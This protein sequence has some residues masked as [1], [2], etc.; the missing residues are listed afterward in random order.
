M[1]VPKDKMIYI[2]YILSSKVKTPIIVPR[3]W[4]LST[5]KGKKAYVPRSGI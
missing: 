2:I 5:Y 1:W 4:M 3:I